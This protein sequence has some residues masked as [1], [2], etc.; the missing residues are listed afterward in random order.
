EAR[1]LSDSILM[2]CKGNPAEVTLQ[3]NDSALTRFANNIIHQNVAERDAQVTIRFFVGKQIGAATTNRTD[4]TSLDELVS[5][6]QTNAKTS[7]EDPNYPGLPTPET[8]HR[9]ACWDPN[10]ASYSP[11]NRARAVGAVCNMAAEKRLNA[12][13]AFS[14]GSRELIVANT[15]GVFTYH[16][17]TNADFQTV[18]MSDDS[19]GRAQESAWKVSELDVEALGKEAITTTEQGHNPR[20]I[21]PGDYT[22]VVEHY[23]TEDLISSLNLYG[24]GAQSVLEGRSWMNDRIGTQATSPLVS[25]WDDGLDVQGSPLPFDF[26]GVPKQR[27]DIV[28]QGVV[29]GPVYDRYS[30]AKMGKPSTGHATPIN[31]RGFGPLALNLFMAPGDKSVGDMIASTDKGLYINRF[32]YTRLVHPRDC[33]ITGMTRDG[34]FMIENGLITHPVKN[35]RY[36]MPY[37]QALA[38]V[39][40]VGKT[41]QLLV[42]AFGGISNHVPAL[43]IH[44][45]T[46]TGSTV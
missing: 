28:K 20:K 15:N 11:E 5:R 43:K 38:N 8:Y 4:E 6:A 30:G 14:T 17:Q 45:F 39:E 10:T 7:P 31:F 34:V 46:F 3:F 23:V 36:T 9:V 37:V 26:E 42:G 2:R 32:W 13:G 16:S 44:S 21:E 27:V 24:M 25:I 33:I 19:S 35:L 41:A 12:S 1:R 29:M 22:V 18:V 40:A